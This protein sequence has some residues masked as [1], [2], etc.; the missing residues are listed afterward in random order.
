MAEFDICVI[1]HITKD[2]IRIK[3]EVVQELVGGTAY[4]TSLALHTLGLRVAVVT[5]TAPE[6]R[7]Q[8]LTPLKERNI[9]VFWQPSAKT[10]I[11]EDIYPTENLDV[12][13]EKVW[14]VADPFVVEDLAGF[15]AKIIHLGPLT[16]AD[17]DRG[18]LAATIDRQE[19]I[20]LDVQGLVRKI[21]PTGDVDAVPWHSGDNGWQWVDIL[22][23]DEKEAQII[24]ATDDLDSARKRLSDLGV[25]E[26][27]ITSGSRGSQIYRQ[28]ELVFIP[29]VTPRKIVDATGCG[30]T[31]MAGYLDR[32][33]HGMDLET[34]GKFAAKI[35]SQKLENFGALVELPQQ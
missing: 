13:F 15:A 21:T 23:A 35:A 27:I 31:Y 30:D 2:I 33:L 11:F 25:K 20:S 6:D 4:Y 24:T 19:I 18:F 29:P 3:G 9:A 17:F 34:S 28:G 32:R 26:I 22:K 16:N 1:G 7:D 12:R 14:A 8:L 10:S 5:K